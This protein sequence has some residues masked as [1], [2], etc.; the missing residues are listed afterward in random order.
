MSSNIL[1]LFPQ[2]L[3]PASKVLVT[4]TIKPHSVCACFWHF[5]NGM[6]ADTRMTPRLFL[7]EGETEAFA[8]KTV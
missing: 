1:C 6:S 4:F 7:Q 3:Q 2:A 5:P 8:R